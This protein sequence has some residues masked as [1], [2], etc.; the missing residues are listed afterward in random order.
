VSGSSGLRAAAPAG[1]RKARRNLLGKRSRRLLAL[2]AALAATAAIAP[3]SPAAAVKV[4][5]LDWQSCADPA[6]RGFQ[7]ATARVPLDYSHPRGPRIHLAVIRHRAS[8]R[9]HRIGTLFFNPGGPSAAGTV[10]LPLVLERL[11]G[12]GAGTL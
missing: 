3:S 7:C 1:E 10:G 2:A 4:P 12:G 6:Q 5:K 8:D 9:A 11:P